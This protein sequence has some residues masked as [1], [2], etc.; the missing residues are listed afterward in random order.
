[1][2]DGTHS[3]YTQFSETSTPFLTLPS[4][5][6]PHIHAVSQSVQPS[7]TLASSL[8]LSSEP[9]HFWINYRAA[10]SLPVRQPLLHSDLPMLLLKL[11]SDSPQP[12]AQTP[13]LGLHRIL[14]GLASVTSWVSP[15]THPCSQPVLYSCWSTR[16]A[17]TMSCFF[18]SFA[19]LHKWISLPPMLFF[20]PICHKF[21]SKTHSLGGVRDQ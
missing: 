9:Q 11:F 5:T 17:S 6:T 10:S 16:K 13:S 1:M 12:P 3:P 21:P 2:P 8:C 20:F 7:P 19:P 4:P 14:P 15:Q 18:F